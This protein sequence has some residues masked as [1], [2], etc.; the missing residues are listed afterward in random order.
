MPKNAINYSNTIIYKLVCKNINIEDCYV[1]HTTNFSKRKY[2]HYQRCVKIN[3]K[4]CFI[5]YINFFKNNCT[6]TK[7]V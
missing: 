4:K 3:S 1:G 2:Q 7:M 6:N 5:K